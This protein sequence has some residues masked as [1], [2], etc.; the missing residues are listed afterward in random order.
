MQNR[1]VTASSEECL[2]KILFTIPS[3][4]SVQM[5]YVLWIRTFF[6]VIKNHGLFF[7]IFEKYELS[8]TL[9][10]EKVP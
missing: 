8:P 3:T 4:T 2:C 7:K 6:H 5:K 10:F 1:N 9:D